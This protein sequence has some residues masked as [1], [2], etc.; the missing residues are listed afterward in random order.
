M[1][2]SN[3]A[4][5]AQNIPNVNKS[6]KKLLSL[7]EGTKGDDFRL[8]IEGYPDLE[9]LVQ[10]AELPDLKREMIESYGPH[11]VK[12]LQEGKFLNAGDMAIS[13]K[14]VINGTAYAALRTLIKD[15]VYF[16]ANLALISESKP[17]S[18]AGT[19]IQLSDCWIEID[20]TSLSVEDGTQLVKPT[21][22]LHY[23]WVSWLDA[24]AATPMEWGAGA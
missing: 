6:Y 20:K 17:S 11:G 10:T 3:I 1:A 7:G 21:G 13:F 18:V 15:K 4:N 19:T 2:T 23:S 8:T 16:Q 22:T 9:F 14:E 5:V 24:E 12:F